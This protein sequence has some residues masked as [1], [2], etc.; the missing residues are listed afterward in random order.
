MILRSIIR[1]GMVSYLRESSIG[2]PV[3]VLDGDK[4]LL[5]N[6]GCKVGAHISNDLS[7]LFSFI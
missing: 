7:L 1:R 6:I 4:I 2:L 3:F 5:P